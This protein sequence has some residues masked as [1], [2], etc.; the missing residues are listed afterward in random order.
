MQV[1][2]GNSMLMDTFRMFREQQET[3]R[4]GKE[5]TCSIKRQRSSRKT[6][7]SSQLHVLQITACQLR[8]C[9]VTSWLQLV[10]LL[11][12]DELFHNIQ[13]Q[14]IILEFPCKAFIF[15]FEHERQY[16]PTM[17]RTVSSCT[18]LPSFFRT[19]PRN[20]YYRKLNQNVQT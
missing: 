3:P 13:L 19:T 1:A 4:K 5:K 14:I 11:K 12:F 7:Q 10:P 18:R 8:Q 6:A 9:I 2:R 16:T 15:A 20:R 17:S